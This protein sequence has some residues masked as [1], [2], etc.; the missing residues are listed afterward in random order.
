MFSA[1]FPFDS[2]TIYQIKIFLPYNRKGGRL[3]DYVMCISVIS[4]GLICRP[5]S[6]NGTGSSM[7][8][9]CSFSADDYRRYNDHQ[10]YQK[11]VIKQKGDLYGLL[12]FSQSKRRINNEHQTKVT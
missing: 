2:K 4:I 5:V 7:A 3:D 11:K 9:N 12:S 6:I 10:G 8:S 1:F